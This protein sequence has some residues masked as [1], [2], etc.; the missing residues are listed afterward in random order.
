M[1]VSVFNDEKKK[2]IQHVQM[3][4]PATTAAVKT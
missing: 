3:V 4:T 1:F 2:E